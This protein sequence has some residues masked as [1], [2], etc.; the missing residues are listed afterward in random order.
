M[1]HIWKNVTVQIDKLISEVAESWTSAD[2]KTFFC[3]SP[4]FSGKTVGWH[5]EEFG[6]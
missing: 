5:A 2:V 3:S 6:H 1:L 4:I